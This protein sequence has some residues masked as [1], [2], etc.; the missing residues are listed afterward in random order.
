[1]LSPPNEEIDRRDGSTSEE[2]VV[3]VAVNAEVVPQSTVAALPVYIV[4]SDHD[5]ECLEDI[6]KLNEEAY[7]AK[8]NLKLGDVVY[9]LSQDARYELALTVPKGTFLQD[10]RYG[11]TD[12]FS[13]ML[14]MIIFQRNHDETKASEQG[15]WRLDEKT[16]TSHVFVLSTWWRFP[17][18][19]PRQ[20]S[21]R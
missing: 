3:M 2:D 17:I 4:V 8:V 14:N 16:H 20:T 12:S 9:E 5:V 19:R 18:G 15:R 10:M 1:M 21:Q 13:T 11:L 6:L 7:E